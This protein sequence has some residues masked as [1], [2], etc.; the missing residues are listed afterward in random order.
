MLLHGGT[1]S[2]GER[3]QATIKNRISY[4]QFVLRHQGRVAYKGDATDENTNISKLSNE[5]KSDAEDARDQ[6]VEDLF[7]ILC[8]STLFCVDL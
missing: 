7:A 5:R 8:F 4:A 2:N 1:I 3:G 6:A